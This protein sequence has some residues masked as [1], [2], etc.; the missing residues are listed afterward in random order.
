MSAAFDSIKQGMTEAI[1]HAAG[2][3]IK[4]VEHKPPDID[5]ESIRNKVGMSRA[6]FASSVGV[7]VGT[8]RDWERGQ[9]TPR[10][11]ALILLNVI[12]REP[13]VLGA[14]ARAAQG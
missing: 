6:E 10:G 2:K 3:P 14:L 13:G 5:V 11:P 1:E 8:V 7:T 9:R 12:A 4:A